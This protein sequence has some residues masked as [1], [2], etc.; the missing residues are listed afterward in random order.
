MTSQVLY[1][2]IL[3]IVVAGFLFGMALDYLN[4]RTLNS[5]MPDAVKG[6]Y[7]EEKYR[8]QQDYQRV[9]YRFG[10]ISGTF[11]F[12]LILAMLYFKGFA[13][14]DQFV[15]SISNS[16]IWQAIMFFGILGLAVD[17]LATPFDVYHTFGIEQK[18]GFNTTTGRTYIFDKIKGWL[19]AGILGGGMLAIIVWLY[20][21]TGAW[22]WV[23]VWGIITF[24]TVFINYFYT[25][26]LLPLFNKLT[27]LEPGDLRT[28]IDQFAE[29][30]G[31]N[32]KNIYTMDGSK[33]STKGNA[34]FSG[35]GK[36]KK[37]VL[38]DTL[39]AGHPNNELVAILAHEIGHY[40]K[41]HIFKGLVIS[42]IQ[43]GVLL[44]IL[45]LLVGS[46]V[47][48]ASLGSPFIGFHMGL[49]AFGILYSPVSEF[50]GIGMNVISRR[51]EYQAD[52]FAAANHC[53]D[54][55]QQALKKLS[56]KNLVNL[57]PHP[58]YVFVYYSH[59]PLMERLKALQNYKI[60]ETE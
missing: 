5:R 31:F 48:S 29:K 27:P 33:R 12:I 57:L 14:L 8:K 52:A 20:N 17:L 44:F 59:P 42:F 4:S 60:N 36:Q 45:S 21:R 50:I 30:T 16:A 35:F 34:Y 58:F 51:H 25:V 3:A 28:A 37:V 7:D 11:S 15:R 49:L 1:Y 56:L 19:L 53:G 26:L 54:D 10:L 32:L 6:I 41:K 23:Y 47:L 2:I 24:F 38:F 39:I 18:F 43:T 13:I 9:N 46:P 22:F 55:L 40:K